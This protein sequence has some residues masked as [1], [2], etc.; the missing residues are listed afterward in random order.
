MKIVINN[1]PASFSFQVEDELPPFESGCEVR[2]KILLF[3]L[4]HKKIKSY[5]HDY[6]DYY[7]CHVIKNKTG[8]EWVLGS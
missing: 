6:E 8:E 1:Y 2:H 3:Q 4:N 7:I 5:S